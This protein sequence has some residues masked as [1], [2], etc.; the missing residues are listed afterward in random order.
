MTIINIK[1]AELNLGT[2]VQCW[3]LSGVSVNGTDY[4]VLGL[5]YVG[6]GSIIYSGGT[7]MQIYLTKDT[8]TGCYLVGIPTYPA[9]LTET[10]IS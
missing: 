2:A 10:V 3:T 4:P 5:Q 1:V 8:N 9:P 7:T 6:G